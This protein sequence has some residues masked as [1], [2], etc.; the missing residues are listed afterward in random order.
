MFADVPGYAPQTVE[1]IAAHLLKR[2]AR[3]DDV[4]GLAAEK[5]L[6]LDAHLGS[7]AQG[8]LRGDGPF[9]NYA[10]SLHI[11][12]QVQPGLL[13]E[14]LNDPTN[15]AHVEVIAAEVIVASGMDHFV[16]P[17]AGLND[18]NVESA[19]AQIKDDQDARELV[20]VP[21]GQG[22]GGRLVEDP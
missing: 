9:M 21:V 19:A 2:L 14:F 8:V 1:Q 11:P 17:F 15:D 22:G 4:D 20:L 3:Q 16:E 6:D 7:L 10:Q 18:G 12:A 13:F 5:V